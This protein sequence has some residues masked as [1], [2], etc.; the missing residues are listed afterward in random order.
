MYKDNF[1]WFKQLKENIYVVFLRLCSLSFDLVLCFV[2]YCQLQIIQWAFNITSK[3]IM[4]IDVNQCSSS[5]WLAWKLGAEII[6]TTTPLTALDLIVDV[7]VGLTKTKTY[8]CC[9]HHLF[10]YICTISE[11]FVMCSINIFP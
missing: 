3:I 9:Y 8:E 11:T 10:L 6:A 7:N 4:A 5:R 2:R 1:K